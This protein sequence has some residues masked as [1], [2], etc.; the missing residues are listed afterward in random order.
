MTSMGRSPKR[1]PIAVLACKTSAAH[2]I[3]WEIGDHPKPVNG[4]RVTWLR[5]ASAWASTAW[6]LARFEARELTCA[7]LGHQRPSRQGRWNAALG[8]WVYDDECPRCGWSPP[9]GRHG[10]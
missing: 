7:L 5:K 8:V 1:V 6:A 4:G 9:R 10:R 2:P 3:S